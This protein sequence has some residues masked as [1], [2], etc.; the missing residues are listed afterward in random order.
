MIT[1]NELIYQLALSKISGLGFNN[2]KN[3]IEIAKSA[4]NIY[5]LNEKELSS[6]IKNENII[7]E[8]IEK[9]TLKEAEDIF[10][11]Y[12]NTL[13]I[14]SYFDDKYP[15]KLK[16]IPNAPFFLYIKG[17]NI[18][19][20]ERILGV[21]GT[22]QPTNYGTDNVK[23]FLSDLND[24]NITTVSGLA[25]GIDIKAHRESIN[26]SIPTIAVLGSGVNYIYPSEHKKDAEMIIEKGGCI[27]SEYEPNNPPEQYKFASRNR[28]IAGLSDAVLVI[29]AG[30][31][32]GTEITAYCANEYNREVFAIPGNINSHK[33]IGCNN[34]IK[35]NIAHITTSYEDIISSLNWIK[36]KNNTKDINT[37]N[38]NIDETLKYLGDDYINI[39]NYIKNKKITSLDQIIDNF[40]N[41]PESKI[42]TIL[43][44]LE[45]KNIISHL[46]GNNY[47]LQK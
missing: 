28:I 8:I 47:F 41:I 1:D 20:N 42:S 16:E 14:L 26:N 2:W 22:R 19:N 39:Y 30:V 23:H 13:T 6:L 44:K 34:L 9:S 33:S 12:N 29:E 15:L 35:N 21:I 7:T 11:R 4:E 40:Y 32:S 3:I 36:N 27:I 45:M 24:Y 18:L 31:K 17:T 37:K 46:P 5:N 43:L 10:E 38:T 25:Y